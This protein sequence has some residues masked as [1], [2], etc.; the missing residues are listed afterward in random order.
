MEICPWCNEGTLSDTLDTVYWE[1]P[2]GTKAIEITDTPTKLCGSC[3]AKFQ[4]DETVKEIEDQ[5]F[6]INTGKLGKS[7][8]FEELM[9]IE[10]LLKRNYFDFS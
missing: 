9:K 5:L 4:S 10:R 6:L 7:T 2:D 1:L 8:S 3:K